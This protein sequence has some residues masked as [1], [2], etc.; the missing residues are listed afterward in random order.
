MTP[1]KPSKLQILMF[2]CPFGCA[3]HS[4]DMIGSFV[5]NSHPWRR[6]GA[7]VMTIFVSHVGPHFPNVEYF[8]VYGSI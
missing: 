3:R 6:P 7:R 2:L 8:E 5:S 1:P 4:G